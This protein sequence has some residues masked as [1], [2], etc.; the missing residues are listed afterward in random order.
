MDSL[1]GQKMALGSSSSQ[2]RGKLALA[3]SLARAAQQSWLGLG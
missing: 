3:A 2:V 1:E